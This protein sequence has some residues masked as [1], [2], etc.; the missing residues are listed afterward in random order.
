[1]KYCTHCGA[2][3]LDEAVMCPK[4]GCAVANFGSTSL[5]PVSDTARPGWDACAIVG[6]ILSVVSCVLSVLNIFGIVSL[7]GMTVSIVGTARVSSKKLRGM[8]LAIAGICVGAIA[9]LFWLMIWILAIRTINDVA[10]MS[11]TAIF[12][13]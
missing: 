4:C 2:E 9:F 7:A 11:A 8:G 3:L 12:G 10:L 1:M 13:G 6:F 5:K